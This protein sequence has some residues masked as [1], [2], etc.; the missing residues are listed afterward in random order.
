[1]LIL[2]SYFDLFSLGILTV[3][4]IN[5]SLSWKLYLAGIL[6]LDYQVF[7]VGMEVL[8]VIIASFSIYI[9]YKTIGEKLSENIYSMNLKNSIILM[10]MTIIIFNCM[11][12]EYFLYAVCA[13]MCLSVLLSIIAI[14]G[15]SLLTTICSGMT[16]PSESYLI[17][18]QGYISQ[19]Y[20]LIYFFSLPR[21][22]TEI[23]PSSRICFAS[24]KARVFLSPSR[25]WISKSVIFPFSSI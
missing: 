8:A 6:N 3:I 20:A 1:M 12:L 11:S 7:I 23:N 25:S 9:L 14:L 16:S 22:T 5:S 2:Y 13:V 10:A 19:N 4:S 17:L 21:P 15:S 24:V 18:P